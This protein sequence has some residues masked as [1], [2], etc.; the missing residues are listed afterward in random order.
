MNW[1]V[2]P[3][4]SDK[5]KELMEKVVEMEEEK[6]AEAEAKAKAEAD[7]VKNN[8]KTLIGKKVKTWEPLLGDK[9]KGLRG[10]KF[11]IVDS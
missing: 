1:S 2:S 4:T 6:E 5:I 10:V 8:G 3:C 9:N 11:K 7:D